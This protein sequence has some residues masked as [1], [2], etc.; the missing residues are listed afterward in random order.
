MNFTLCPACIMVG[1]D[2]LVLRHS[3]PHFYRMDEDGDITCWVA[4]LNWRLIMRQGHKCVTVNT[5]RCGFDPS[6]GEMKYLFK[7]I[8][9]YIRSG[10]GCVKARHWGSSLNA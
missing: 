1:R 3:G 10:V 6:L 2:S 7:C 4:E 8:F 9:S 5:I